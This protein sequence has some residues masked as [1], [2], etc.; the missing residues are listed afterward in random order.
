[1]NVKKVLYITIAGVAVLSLAGCKKSTP[2][3][4][5]SIEASEE[6]QTNE[7]ITAMGIELVTG[8]LTKLEGNTVS[9][10][11]VWMTEAQVGQVAK[12]FTSEAYKCEIK[13]LKES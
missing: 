6:P 5:P 7:D 4:E 13:S 10:N 12:T 11:G 2:T 1:M 8:L 3:E 9:T